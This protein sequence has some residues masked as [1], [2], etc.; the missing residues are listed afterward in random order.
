MFVAK[1]ESVGTQCGVLRKRAIHGISV[2]ASDHSAVVCEVLGEDG[3]DQAFA[4]AALA[5][6]C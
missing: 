1:I 4:D 5:L 2:N 6:Q 3:S